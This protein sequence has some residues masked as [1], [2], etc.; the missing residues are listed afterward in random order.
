M[1][2]VDV[3]VR[4]KKIFVTNRGPTHGTKYSQIPIKRPSIKRP[5]P[6]RRS[7]IKVPK[8]LSV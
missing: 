3:L 4:D 6:I 1:N 8:A 7:V 5:T 2:S